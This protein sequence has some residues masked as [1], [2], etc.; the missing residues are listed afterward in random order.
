MIALINP[1]FYEKSTYYFSFNRAKYPNPSFVYLGGYLESKNIPFEIID[2]KFEDINIPQIIE[3]LINLK[4]RIIGLTS[5]TTEIDY[6]NSIIREIKN[7]FPDSFVV[8]GGVHATALPFETISANQDID[9]LIAGE[10]E[11]VLEKLSTVKNLQKVLPDIPG[12]YF[13]K[14]GSIQ[15]TPPQALGDNLYDYGKAAFHLWKKAEKYFV[16]TYRGCPFTCSFCFR[17]FGKRSR[18]RNPEDVLSELEYIA[19]NAPQSELSILDATFGLHRSYTQKILGEMIRRGLNKKLKWSCSTRVDVS[20]REFFQ[21]MKDAGCVTVSFGIE[22]GSNRILKSTGKNITIDRCMRAVREAQS[23]GLKT[24]GYYIF[25]HIEET[26]KEAEE[27]LNLI[28]KMNC[29]EIAVGVMVPWP[30]TQV[31]ELARVNQGGYRLLST[32]FSKYDKYFGSVMEFKNFSINYLDM[33]RIKAYLYLYLKNYRFGDLT[34]FL[35]SSRKHAFK[36]TKQIFCR[37]WKD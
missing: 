17:A 31:F 28:W 11:Y 20:D 23:V 19:N 6:V 18:Q 5:T 3:R 21:L 27:T 8:I 4:P 36:K 13:R 22:S 34:K 30:G 16:F 10:G 9:A 15:H 29:N 35:W 32:D 1:P 24:T 2:A 7:N 37:F 26:R 14:N 33:I 12:I 25:G